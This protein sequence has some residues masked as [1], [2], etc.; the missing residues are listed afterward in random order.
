MNSA[1]KFQALS[2]LQKWGSGYMETKV[3]N[4]GETEVP[5]R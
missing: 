4:G 5:S 1:V 2:P 3:K